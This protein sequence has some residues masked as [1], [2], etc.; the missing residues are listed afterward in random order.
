MTL[1]VPDSL[2][3]LGCWL[4]QAGYAFTTVTPT[5]HGRVNV[6]RGAEVA[7]TL[8]DV[9]G[10]SRPFPADL[11]PTAP[12]VWLR[13]SG[14]V[15]QRG[16]LLHSKVR[17]STLGGQ[18]YAHSAYPT[19]A[20]DAVFFGPDT[21]R[22]AALIE[23][24]LARQPLPDGTRILDIGCGAG[25]GGIAAALASP[26]G[27]TEL[28]LA[29]INPQALEFARANAALAG[30]PAVRFQQSDLYEAL[31]DGFDL[32]VANPPYLLD[33]GERTYRH[34]GGPLGS[35]LSLRIVREG[36]ARLAPGG[37]LVLYTGAPV[38]DGQDA[39]GQEAQALL[40]QAGCP[41]SYREIDPDVFGEELDAPAYR[42]AER[43]AAVALVATRPLVLGGPAG[44]AP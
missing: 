7:S 26:A 25:P 32:I 6:R 43:I 21:Y 27:R 34:G 17:F 15:A 11:L 23:A 2:V 38:V 35:G 1:P 8:R 14:L 22:F 33:A 42:Q 13:D 12:M 10:W 24:E 19:T 18:L 5:T 29:D 28:L 37:R 4:R 9:F 39:F 30:L 44:P 20:A 41:F 31:G 40:R 16:E 36:L 3:L